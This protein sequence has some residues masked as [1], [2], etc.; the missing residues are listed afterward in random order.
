MLNQLSVGRKL[1]LMMVMPVIGLLA[2]FFIA[3]TELKASNDGVATIYDDRVVPLKNL[4]LISTDYAVL[5]I[6]AVNKTNAGLMSA[7]E[8]YRGIQ[9]AQSRID[10]TWK[11]YTA[12]DMTE[13]EAQ[14]VKEAQVLFLQANQSID[15]LQDKLSGMKGTQK[16][17]L[18]QFDGT[19]YST[20]DPISD[21]IAR[22]YSAARSKIS[23][24]CPQ[25]NRVKALLAD[26]DCLR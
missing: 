15:A 1:A 11:V 25:N 7:E 22:N 4:Y 9:E 14:L 24:S 2:T 20:I 3:E 18:D 13:K 23:G 16:G 8:A 26:T 10:K 19:L 12:T 21:K 6:D 5:I 17:L